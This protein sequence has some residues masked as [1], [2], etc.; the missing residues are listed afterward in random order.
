MIFWAVVVHKSNTA[1]EIGSQVSWYL[2]SRKEEDKEV[3][4]EKLVLPH[5]EQIQLGLVF[6][7]HLWKPLEDAQLSTKLLYFHILPES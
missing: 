1:A 6:Y 3:G 2:A 7:V 4:E 5:A